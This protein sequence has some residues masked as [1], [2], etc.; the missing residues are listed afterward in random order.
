MILNVLFLL[1]NNSETHFL[2]TDLHY[3]NIWSDT[4]DLL[5]KESMFAHMHFWHRTAEIIPLYYINKNAINQKD[6]HKDFEI[7]ITNNL[8]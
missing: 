7:I 8:S 5:F 3:L 1:D 2:Q 4:R 6:Q